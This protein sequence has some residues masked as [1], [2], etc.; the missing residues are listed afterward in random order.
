MSWGIHPRVWFVLLLVVATGSVAIPALAQDAPDV[1][2]TWMAKVEAM[3]QSVE[4]TLSLKQVDGQWQGTLKGRRG[5]TEL[6]SVEVTAT[7]LRFS[8]QMDGPQGQ[9]LKITYSGALNE[10]KTLIEG[11]MTADMP[12]APAQTMNFAKIDD[13]SGSLT[14]SSGVK[15]YRPGSG[16]AGAWVGEIETVDGDEIEVTLN[17]DQENG[18]WVAVLA[19]PF[20]GEVRGE[21]LRVSDTLI[22]FNFRPATAPFPST[23]S[24]TYVAADDRV[25]GTISQRGTSRFIK[26][27]RK[28]GTVILTTIGPDGKI[29]EP[30][31]IRHTYKFAVAARLSYWPALHVIKDEV[32]NL[33]DITTGELNYD[34]T[35]RYFILDGFNVFVRG[36]RGGLGYEAL[37]SE[38]ASFAELGL[39]SNAYLK[40]DGY[41]LGIMGYLGNIMMRDSKFNPYLTAAGGRTTWAL[42]SDGRDTPVLL[43]NREPFQGTDWAVALGFGTEYALTEHFCLELELLWRYFMTE[44]TDRFDDTDN[45]W[46]N[47]HAWS[48]SFGLT[49]GFF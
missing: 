38:L 14:D 8:Y 31:P 41:E 25:T 18:D 16:P 43:A 46:S 28:P 35:L 2:G 21:D 24:G 4:V 13:G 19:D 26:F 1:T 22:A 40:L 27:E 45:L 9:K 10:D 49:W 30:A 17:L 5:T 44:D 37:E 36:F 42:M 47:T 48:L 23:F 15:R 7:R 32:Y 34:G 20:M 3:G 33:N 12:G 11:S 39:T 6:E 29:Q